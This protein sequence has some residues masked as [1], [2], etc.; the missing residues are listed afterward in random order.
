MNSE[1]LA[2]FEKLVN[3]SF[4][5][6]YEN[7]LNYIHNTKRKNKQDRAMELLKLD[8]ANISKLIGI[9]VT[10]IITDIEPNCIFPIP[11]PVIVKLAPITEFMYNEAIRT[12]PHNGY[13]FDF[14]LAKIIEEVQDLKVAKYI[15]SLTGDDSDRCFLCIPLTYNF[16]THFYL[17]YKKLESLLSGYQYSGT[18]R[19]REEM[20][21]V[22]K[23]DL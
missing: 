7:V 21:K 2:K 22:R 18:I 20:M 19:E 17:S 8:T 5:G 12:I 9:G 11:M 15:N 6:D 23:S 4:E 13:E 3:D 14:V 1:L 16:R 10:S